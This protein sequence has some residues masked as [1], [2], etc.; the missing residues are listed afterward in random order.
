M[1]FRSTI[2]RL[3]GTGRVVMHDEPEFAELRLLFGKPR[4]I[5]QRSI[6]VV[7]CDRIADSCGYSVP[8]M[9]YV[10]DR[11]LLDRSQ[12]RRDDAYYERYWAERNATS[13]DGLPALSERP[14]PHASA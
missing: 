11:D 8:L 2:V 1:L 5:G 4:E 3:Q 13:I 14:L 10:G 9:D 12:E 6:V 7:T